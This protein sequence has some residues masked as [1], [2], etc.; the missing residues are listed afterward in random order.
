MTLRHFNE[1]IYNKP[2][3]NEYTIKL[4]SNEYTK[5]YILTNHMIYL[6]YLMEGF[7]KI[8]IVEIFEFS[9]NSI[10]IRLT[11]DLKTCMRRKSILVKDLIH[12]KSDL[13]QNMCWKICAGY[14]KV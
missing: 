4:H 9:R 2:H 1:L 6:D 10:L 14:R 8:L 5:N 12:V 13:Q 7:E 3:S 11:S